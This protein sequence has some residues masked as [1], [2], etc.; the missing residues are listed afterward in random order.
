MSDF[1]AY[2]QALVPAYPGTGRLRDPDSLLWQY[3]AVI[4]NVADGYDDNLAE[5]FNDLSCRDF[6]ELVLRDPKASEHAPFRDFHD[7]VSALDR[8]FKTFLAPQPVAPGNRWWTTHLP[9]RAGANLRH[10]MQ[11]I[12]GYGA[13]PAEE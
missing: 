9:L 5:Y 4:T 7:A 6:I 13:Q 12:F 10:D 8:R 11:A 2:V 1:N 3:A